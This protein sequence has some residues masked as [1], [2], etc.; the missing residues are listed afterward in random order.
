MVGMARLERTT[1][2]SRTA[3]SNLLSYIPI[4]PYRG[5]EPR[6]SLVGSQVPH[7]MGVY[8]KHSPVTALASC[9][10]AM[11]VCA[12]NIAL[13]DLSCDPLPLDELQAGRDRERL[14]ASVIKVQDHYVGLAAVDAWMRQQIGNDVLLVFLIGG[15]P[16]LA[17][18]VNILL[19]VQLVVVASF[20]GMASLTP[21]SPSSSLLVLESELI[22]WLLDAAASTDLHDLTV[23]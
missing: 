1:S 13:G 15:P 12:A 18:L 11:A 4:E 17:R 21:R 23:R 22:E 2:R 16:P 14:V 8:G 9:F 19:T 10:P 3:R 20:P 7:L 5:V 6:L